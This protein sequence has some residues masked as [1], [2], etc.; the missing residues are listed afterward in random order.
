MRFAPIPSENTLDG[1]LHKKRQN[2]PLTET[3]IAQ[4]NTAIQVW[5]GKEYH[6]LSWIMQFHIGAIRNTNSRMFKLL[7]ADSG[8]DSIG[9]RSYAEALAALLNEMD[10]TDQLPTTIPNWFA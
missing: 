1:L 8:C 10:Q 4:F 6:R 2:Q 7:G 9:D 5:L 3:E